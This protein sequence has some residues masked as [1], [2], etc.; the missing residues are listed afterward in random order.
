MHSG[1]IIPLHGTF[2][3]KR[4]KMPN[5]K[6]RRGEETTDGGSTPGYRYPPKTKPCKGERSFV[7]SALLLLGSNI[8]GDYYPRL[9]SLQPFKLCLLS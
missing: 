5:R 2:S 8:N 6:P 4:R 3:F 9:W 1:P 7:P